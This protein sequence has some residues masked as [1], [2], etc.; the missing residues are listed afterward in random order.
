MLAG[1][2]ALEFWAL[3]VKYGLRVTSD[4][5][6]FLALLR[7]M[8]LHPLQ[9]VSPFVCGAGLETSH[10]T[11]YMQVLAWL[12]K[13]VAPHHAGGVPAPDPLAAYRVLAVA[14]VVVT[15]L[16]LHASFLWV[17]RSA[18]TRAA[19]ISLPV[20]LLLFGPAHVIWAGDLTFNG[21]LYASFYPQTLGLALL[22]YTLV[23]VT[24]GSGLKP[25]AFTTLAVA[26][27]MVV[28]SFHRFAPR[29]A[30][31]Q[32]GSP[33]CSPASGQLVRPEPRTHRRVRTG[34]TLAFLLAR[35]C[36]RRGGRGRPSA[37]RCLRHCPGASHG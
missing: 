37:R 34:G 30:P 12:W 22:L 27:T 17:R 14:G 24:S 3:D 35:P 36:T 29:P 11:P 25:V 23:F 28:Q 13:L 2:F 20:L 31:R 4:T 18:G 8:T 10:A 9:P 19:W 7:E 6:T 33:A 5:P 26:A 16:A 1:L 32:R 15:A 21:F